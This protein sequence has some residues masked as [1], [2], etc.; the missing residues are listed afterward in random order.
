M[1]R[2]LC[3][4]QSA[5]SQLF[6][7]PAGPPQFELLES[8]PTDLFVPPTFKDEVAA[9]ASALAQDLRE[10]RQGLLQ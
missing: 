3:A 4:P 10:L 2:H 5:M 8:P 9:T 6:L 7:G 1:G